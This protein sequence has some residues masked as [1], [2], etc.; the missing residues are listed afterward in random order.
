MKKSKLV[1]ALILSAT[2]LVSLF[3]FGACNSEDSPIQVH[4]HTFVEQAEYQYL[5]SAATCT[6]SAVYY[7]SCSECGERS[8][9]TFTYG[10]YADHTFAEYAVIEDVTVCTGHKKI[11]LCTVCKTQDSQK[12]DDVE[13]PSSDKWTLETEP[14]ENSTGKIVGTCT[15]CKLP[16]ERILP[17]LSDPRYDTSSSITASCDVPGV[18]KYVYT[19]NNDRFEFTV[20]STVMHVLNKKAIA[21]GN[22]VKLVDDYLGDYTLDDLVNDR[23]D[24]IGFSNGAEITCK[25]EGVHGFFKCDSCNHT[26]TAYF[27]KS[28]DKFSESLQTDVQKKKEVAPTCDS[29]GAKY[30]TCSGCEKEFEETVARIGHAFEYKLEKGAGNTWQ[31]LGVCKNKFKGAS[32]GATDNIP[33][34]ADVAVSTKQEATC[35]KGAI[36][37]YV[38]NGFELLYEEST[39]GVLHRYYDSASKVDKRVESSI[40]GIG[41]HVYEISE[42]PNITMLGDPKNALCSNLGNEAVFTCADCGK[43]FIVLVKHPHTMPTDPS[44]ITHTD[45]TCVDDEKT[46]YTCTACNEPVTIVGEPKL[47]HDIEVTIVTE[48]TAEHE[49]KVKVTC[50]HAGCSVNDSADSEIVLPEFGVSSSDDNV[51]I[52]SR[53]KTEYNKLTNCATRTVTTY[54][55]Y[56]KSV[57]SASGDEEWIELKTYTVYTKW[58]SG[59][60]EDGAGETIIRVRINGNYYEGY[61]CS[62]CG[63]FIVTNEV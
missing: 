53:S 19:V 48:P 23:V 35:S 18:K 28:H 2:A 13:L 50:K 36:R 51:K 9:E 22:D 1:I 17:E 6:S 37:S 54:T 16:A 63:K 32:C 57:N 21:L 8:E 60:P 46:Q 7:K 38:Y 44:S 3:A 12:E 33:D 55:Y 29:D 43:H 45:A 14:T 39:T 11:R 42:L 5:V 58:T 56:Y 24:N 52:E 25:D 47:G 31:V 27:K 59:H 10:A 30:Y 26:Y 20:T 34:I 61:I 41:T 49:G 40:T 4:E 15:K 62:A